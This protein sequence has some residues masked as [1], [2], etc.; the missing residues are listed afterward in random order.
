LASISLLNACEKGPEVTFLKKPKN[1]S[2]IN[3]KPSNK[4]IPINP[5]PNGPLTNFSSSF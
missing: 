2:I 5:P 4:T 1:E 3:H